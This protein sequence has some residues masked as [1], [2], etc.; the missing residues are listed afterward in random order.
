MI[1]KRTDRETTYSSQLPAEAPAS[2]PLSGF[3]KIR[4]KFS[5]GVVI[6]GAESRRQLSELAL[7]EKIEICQTPR[8]A[9]F[10]ETARSIQPV[11][12]LCLTLVEETTNLSSAIVHQFSEVCNW[13]KALKLLRNLIKSSDW[14]AELATRLRWVKS[15]KAGPKAR[16]CEGSLLQGFLSVTL[17]AHRAYYL[18]VYIFIYIYRSVSIEMC[19]YNI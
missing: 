2:F 15:G 3:S 9:Q 14:Q 19:V 6:V 7:L 11:N 16:K 18:M 4:T 17:Y 13:I 10:G 12:P 8:P 1:T 5:L